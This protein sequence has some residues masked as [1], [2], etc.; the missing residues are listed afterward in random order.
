MPNVVR[1]GDINAAGGVCQLG[2]GTVT[3]EGSPVGFPGSP[4]TPHACCG[5]PGC[6]SHCNA[7]TQG[8]SSTVTCEGKPVLHS[9]DIDTCGHKR[10]TF[11]GTV[12]VGA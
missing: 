3:C 12:T 1:K 5:L 6:D 10:Q 7:T 2:A 9:N 11:A 4:V 8:G